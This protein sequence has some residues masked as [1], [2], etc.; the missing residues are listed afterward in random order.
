MEELQMEELTPKKKSFIPKVITCLVILTFLIYC[1][2]HFIEPKQLIVKEYPVIN[3]LIPDSFN[4]FKIVQFSD[5]YFGGTIT[6]KEL[7]NIV[8]KINE[9]K[10]DILVFTGNLFDESIHLSNDSKNNLKNIL[11]KTTASIGKYSIKGNQDYSDISFFEEVMK[12]ANFKV[13]NNE[14]IPIYYKGTTP[15]YLSGVPSISRK[16]HDL[17]KCFIQE[18][19]KNAYQ[20]LLLH[21][22]ILFD[23]ISRDTNL[24]LSGHSLGGLIRVPFLGGLIPFE[25]TGDYEV[26]K[27]EMKNST[28]YVS[29]GLGTTKANLRFLNPPS[30][31][32]Y[33]LY[34]S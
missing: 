6:E 3:K 18:E 4:G 2:M 26:G 14:N 34:N 23:E 7:E 13:L 17:S 21:E 30:I 9:L 5:I 32:L 27:Y 11:Q 12:E 15:I 29:S 25:N 1:Y 31:T 24:V 16:E 19:E 10:P 28:L 20:I 22:P 33:R 8:T